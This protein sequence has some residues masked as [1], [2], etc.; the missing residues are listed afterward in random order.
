M[1]DHKLKLKLEY[2]DLYY[3]R[4]IL[5]IEEK[6]YISK[7]IFK[8]RV[9]NLNEAKSDNSLLIE[10]KENLIFYSGIKKEI[11]KSGQLNEI[12]TGISWL[13]AAF[14]WIG[15]IKNALSSTSLGKW[16][17]E[18]VKSI[19]EKIFPK[20]KSDPND[21]TEKFQKAAT[22]LNKVLGVNVLAYIIAWWRKKGFLVKPTKEE[23]EAAKKTA[24][25]VYKSIMLFFIILCIIKLAA[26][27]LPL[28]AKG[29]SLAQSAFSLGAG[30]GFAKIASVVIGKALSGAGLKGAASFGWNV[31]SLAD[32]VH[33]FKKPEDAYKEL[34]PQIN[35]AE[36]EID[37]EVG[38]REQNKKDS[39]TLKSAGG[40]TG[41]S[42]LKV[43]DSEKIRFLKL[44]GIKQY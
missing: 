17:S 15:N 8:N 5:T 36:K 22:V 3:N 30:A 18:K 38:K 23:V 26:V 24:T 42:E 11:I 39:E 19:A 1:N 28:G 21:W 43:N 29:L 4:N 2:L 44:S 33:H 37:A 12:H 25:A 31:Y 9:K 35:A 6:R 32:K 20:L 41:L 13:D 34:E 27:L 14:N 16:L 10:L 7:Q 40:A